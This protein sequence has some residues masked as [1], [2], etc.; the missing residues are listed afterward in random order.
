MPQGR[1]TGTVA[2]GGGKAPKGRAGAGRRPVSRREET[3]ANPRI[4][5]RAKQTCTVGEEQTVEVVQNHAG[6]TWE[7]L[8][9]SPR[10]EREGVFPG[11]GLS[12]FGRWRG[13]LWKPQERQSGRQGR[14]ARIG[15]R[16]KSRRQDQEGRARHARKY[17][18]HPIVGT[19]RAT[20]REHRRSRRGAA[21]PTAAEAIGE[22]PPWTGPWP[23][24]RERRETVRRAK[25]QPLVGEG[26][27]FIHPRGPSVWGGQ[28]S[29]PPR[30]CRSDE[31]TYPP[32]VTDDWLKGQAPRRLWCP[33]SQDATCRTD[34]SAHL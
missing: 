32:A 30:P 18:A 4:G 8:A 20:V 7:R 14:T 24:R 9:V 2:I 22:L 13:D 28:R 27:G 34:P 26:G 3:T 15:T 31:P 5:S 21:K 11:I 25:A 17:A 33:A 10:R 6:G 16:R 19:S 1:S 29:D 23:S 12:G